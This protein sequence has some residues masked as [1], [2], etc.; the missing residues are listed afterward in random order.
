LAASPD[1]TLEL[2]TEEIIENASEFTC[3]DN[4][5]WVSFVGD[6]SLRFYNSKR[7]Q[8]CTLVQISPDKQSFKPIGRSYAGYEWE[9]ASGEFS[10]LKWI[11][12]GVSCAVDL[13]TLSAG[14]I[15]RLATLDTSNTAESGSM[16][17]IARFLEQSTFGS[18][19]EDIRSLF[20]SA[21]LLPIFAQWILQQQ[22]DVSI[23]SHREFFRQRLNARMETASYNAAVSHPCQIGTRYRRYAFSSKDNYKYLEIE[24]VGSKKILRI[25]GF[26]RTVVKGPIFNTGDPSKVWPDGR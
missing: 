22:N 4:A 3:P 5:G 12:D 19:I 10:Y 7:N 23:T 1:P 13:P 25:D 11:C 24:S 26:V 15:Y 18:T 2:A 17:E 16:N 21:N 6:G 14:S 8:V 20:G 9:A